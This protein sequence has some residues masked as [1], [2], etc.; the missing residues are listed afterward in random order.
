MNG[1]V[2]AENILKEENVNTGQQLGMKESTN[3]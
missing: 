2:L 3:E 1:S